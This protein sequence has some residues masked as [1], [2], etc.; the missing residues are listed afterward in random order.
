VSAKLPV[1]V[2]VVI[3]TPALEVLLLERAARAGYWQSVT[4]SLERADEPL[5]E[6]AAREVREET[7]IRV[8]PEHL[9]RWPIAY[10]FEIYAE[11][12]WRFA[13]GTVYNT[14]HV[15]SLELPAPAAPVL[16]ADEH[17]A[18]R[19]LGWREAAQQC[20]SWSNRDAIR[21]LGTRANLET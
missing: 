8:P 18:Y 1:S 9:V 2:L 11:W 5:A 13:P 17:R 12:R 6:A 7:G 3:H 16:A 4:G 14:E 19:W 15:F 21:L 20:F 10:T